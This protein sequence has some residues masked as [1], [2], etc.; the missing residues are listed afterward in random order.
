MAAG[1][2]ITRNYA[3]FRGVDFSNKEVSLV[4][5]PD[6]LNMWK[7]YKNNLG[8][9]IETRPD[10]ELV[11]EYDNS[12]FGQF[13]YKVGNTKMKIVHSGTKLYRVDNNGKT[14]LFAGMKPAKSNAFVYN[15]MLYIKDGINYL[16]YDGETIGQVVGFIP[17]TSIARKPN[18]GGTTYQ[19]VN[20]LSAYRKNTFLADGTSTEYHL[21]AQNI[22]GEAPTVLVNGN[23][24]TYGKDFDYDTTRGV[25]T[26]TNAPSEPLTVGQDNVTIVYKKTVPGYADRINKCTILQ[27]FDNRVFFS[28]NQDYPNTVWHCGLNDPT[29]CS[30]L[31]YY[32]EGLD[33]APVRSMVAGN[34]ALWVFKEPSQANTTVFYHNPTIDSEYGKIYPSTHSSIST[35]CVATGINFNDDIC[36]FSERGMEAINGDVTTEQVVAHRSSLIDRRLLNEPNYKDMI[37]EEWEGYLLVIVDN[38]VYLAD[39]R[40]MFQ[41][42]NHNEYEWFYWELPIN[43]TST[44]VDEGILYLGSDNGIYKFGVTDTY[45]EVTFTEEDG[46]YVLYGESTQETRS[47]KNLLNPSNPYSANF[48]T[49]SYNNG[50]LTVSSTATNTT[51]F[52][53]WT[54]NL[55]AGET[56][57]FSGFILEK[58]GMFVI[59]INN[60][61]EKVFYYDTNKHVYKYTAT[62]DITLSVLIYAN[63]DIPTTSSSCTYKEIMVEKSEEATNFEQYGATPSP[64]LP[65][66]IVNTYKAGKYKTIINGTEYRFTLDDDLRSAKET[67]D[68]LY[69]SN[70]HLYL[71]KNV[72]V[73]VYNGS[74]AWGVSDTTPNKGFYSPLQTA[75]A[76]GKAISTHFKYNSTT[77]IEGCIG[78]SGSQNLWMGITEPDNITDFKSWLSENNVI[79]YYELARLSTNEID[80][81]SSPYS[82]WTTPE[83]EF[84]N[85]QYQKTTNKRGCVVDM[86][87][88]EVTVSVK[89][90]NSEFEDINTY[91]NIKGYVVSRIKKKKWKSIQLK[92]SSNKPFG[93]ISSTLEAYIGS[94]VKR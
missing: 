54:Y 53:R 56:I 64:E 32:N 33:T 59:Q 27:V 38:H 82:Y 47:G 45:K 94:Y 29:Y 93:L 55:A 44:R 40:A 4:R 70:G 16:K 10:I 50:I 23:V 87:G 36:F 34:N 91:Q 35:G 30:D 66:E 72:G 26:F 9:C 77:W 81:I 12:V 17:T 68:K 90:D 22:D 57:V 73:K 84:K 61:T 89:I 83:D 6:S 18:G 13:F 76:N 60:V 43:V 75:T 92:F 15:N 65:S 7:N 28:G 42:E 11:E 19:D 14:E 63:N 3:E 62:E 41:N 21:D 31:D 20:M 46:E 52:A 67:K 71:E 39:S 5:S 1:D 88:D 85:P 25:V 78:L 51:P 86:M 80:F 8:K 79:V 24:M 2:L 37:L 49:T 74:E 58:K 69:L 48:A